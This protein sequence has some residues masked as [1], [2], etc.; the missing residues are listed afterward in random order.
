MIYYDY[1]ITV[2]DII[3]FS[4]KFNNDA[5]ERISFL[6]QVRVFNKKTVLTHIMSMYTQ[7]SAD[8]PPRRRTG[9][10]GGTWVH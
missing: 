6:L 7:E 2:F 8:Q 3:Q 9:V 1:Y 10:V 4:H 5:N